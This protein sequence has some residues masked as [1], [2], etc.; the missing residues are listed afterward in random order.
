MLAMYND[1]ESICCRR[2][3]AT[4]VVVSD[5]RSVMDCS[6]EPTLFLRAM[7]KSS[8]VQPNSIE[9]DVDCIRGF[10]RQKKFCGYCSFCR[11]LSKQGHIM[12]VVVGTP[13]C[14]SRWFGCHYY[15]HILRKQYR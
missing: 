5:K 8:I 9:V 6:P 2:S 1:V 10:H 3:N 7:C 12:K 15:V 14:Q 13:H 11:R 4:S